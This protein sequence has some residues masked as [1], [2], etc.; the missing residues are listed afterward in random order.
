MVGVGEPGANLTQSPSEVKG[1]GA[2]PV[3]RGPQARVIQ[4]SDAL[5]HS[6]EEAELYAKDGRYDLRKKVMLQQLKDYYGVE[7]E[8]ADRTVTMPEL[9]DEA[10]K[11]YKDPE[12]AAR[13]IAEAIERD[14]SGQ[15]HSVD[16]STLAVLYLEMVS[17][18]KT[19]LE[20]RDAMDAARGKPD[21]AEKQAAYNV[22]E[23]RLLQMA[24][25]VA[26]VKRSH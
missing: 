15:T 13:V 4:P 11:V 19:F 3:A 25:A 10:E 6:S 24:S 7:F 1:S 20:A 26:N 14:K 22:A 21:F 5:Y 17:R 2:G 23:G 16:G 12:T 8:F 18:N 9:F